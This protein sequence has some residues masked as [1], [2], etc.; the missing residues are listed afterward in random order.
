[1]GS[2]LFRIVAVVGMLVLTGPVLWGQEILERGKPRVYEGEHLEAVGMPV[3][4]IGTGN[5]WITGDGSLSVWQIFNALTEDARLPGSF[6]AVRAQAE[7]E[8]PVVRALD[9]EE[10][11]GFPPAAVKSFRGDYPFARL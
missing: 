10:R 7:G 6:F 2:H 1:M 8:E 9:G 4:G 5:I 3:G 11:S